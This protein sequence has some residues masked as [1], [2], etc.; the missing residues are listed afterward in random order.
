MKRDAMVIRLYNKGL[1]DRKIGLKLGVTHQRVSQI[2]KR[3]GRTA[4]A[5]QLRQNK[6]ALYEQLS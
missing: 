4:K 3:L 5:T 1:T 6:K 2:R